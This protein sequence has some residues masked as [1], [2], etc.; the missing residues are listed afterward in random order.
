[1]GRQNSRV[2]LIPAML[3]R[4]KIGLAPGYPPQV[5]VSSFFRCW[6]AILLCQKRLL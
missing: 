6:L 2:A 3:H 1:M 5:Q 4:F